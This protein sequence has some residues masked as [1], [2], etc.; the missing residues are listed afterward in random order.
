MSNVPEIKPQM[1]GEVKSIQ[2]VQRRNSR[3]AVLVLGM[4]RSGTSAVAGLISKLGIGL[5]ED[6][7]EAQADNEKGFFESTT[8]MLA[9]ERLL[10]AVG[11]SW[12]GL[13]DLSGVAATPAGQAFL[14]EMREYLEAQFRRSPFLLLK[15][16]RMCRILETWLPLIDEL[17]ADVLAVH[18]LRNPLAVSASL[19]DRNAFSPGRSILIWLEHVLRAERQ[20]RGL[21][22]L[23]VNFDDVLA[24]WRKFVERFE[25]L[26]IVPSGLSFASRIDIEAFLSEHARHHRFSV[27]DVTDD[28]TLPEWVRE[29]FST[30]ETAAKLGEDPDAAPLDNAF[31]EF[32]LARRLFNDV[33]LDL[34]RLVRQLESKL[35]DAQI[36]A[37]RLKSTLD[38]AQ[39]T[40]YSESSSLRAELDAAIGRESFIAGAH[41]Q[42]ERD[43]SAL[44]AELAAFVEREATLVHDNQ[45]FAEV[46]TV[47]RSELADRSETELRLMQARDEALR[48]IHD[49]TNELAIQSERITQLLADLRQS[50]RTAAS[51]RE[52]SNAFD[53]ER[54]TM[55]HQHETAARALSENL[56]VAQREADRQRE[57][58]LRQRRRA[59]ELVTYNQY[60]ERNL[61]ELENTVREIR[62]SSSWRITAPVRRAK[63][64]LQR[65]RKKRK[66]SDIGNADAGKDGRPILD[67][68]DAAET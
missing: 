36:E 61:Q 18:V 23:F 57:D 22:R 30:L 54:E 19:L 10:A 58:A 63:T 41:S 21:Q 1:R 3:L 25:A 28:R 66:V 50:E 55:I 31:H 52:A 8:I 11:S 24:D 65:A 29:T 34:Q 59:D 14:A 45:Q 17:D 53:R 12:N 9:H 64:W 33:A 16:P 7:L 60:L 15:D 38:L 43:V 56:G 46:I 32:S 48:T 26:G 47:L 68:R 67:N 37:E 2:K 27:S 42:L 39:L 49:Q 5:P 44:R 13:D 40:H 62:A 20:T 6:L 35:S 51:L 4:H